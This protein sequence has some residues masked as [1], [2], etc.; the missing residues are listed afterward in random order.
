MYC[1]QPVVHT[2]R[3][4]GR[5]AENAQ[6]EVTDREVYFEAFG[7]KLGTVSSRILNCAV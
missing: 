1:L 3:G 5:R 6:D 2:T 4:H 7:R